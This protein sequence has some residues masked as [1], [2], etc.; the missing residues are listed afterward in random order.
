[1]R[2]A[3]RRVQ[4]ARPGLGA[5]ALFAA[6]A[7][8]QGLPAVHR[9]A[10]RQHAGGRGAAHGPR[11]GAVA[12]VV[13]PAG[14]EARARRLRE[15]SVPR[16]ARRAGRGEPARALPG[17]R[18]GPRHRDAGDARRAERGRRALVPAAA[19]REQ[20]VQRVSA[21]SAGLRDD[22]RPADLARLLG[23]ARPQAAQAPGPY[24][25]FQ[26]GNGGEGEGQ[27]ENRRHPGARRLRPLGASGA[28][29]H[30][31]HPVQARHAAARGRLRDARAGQPA[32]HGGPASELAAQAAARARALA[33][34]AKSRRARAPHG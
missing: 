7:A 20:A 10:A 2:R 17:G 9:A 5:A 31:A 16:A 4:S 26:A 23:G 1:M 19:L 11:H 6:R 21:R 8:R 28:R 3:A 29:L 32:G 25:R 34:R 12:A 15:L 27:A 22:A 33:R 13:D 24:R 18:R 30:R 14:R